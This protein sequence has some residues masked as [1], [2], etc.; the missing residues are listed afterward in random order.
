MTKVCSPVILVPEKNP[1]KGLIDLKY[2]CVLR[3]VLLHLMTYSH[4]RSRPVFSVFL[5]LSHLSIVKGQVDFSTKQTLS[6]TLSKNVWATVL[7]GSR[8]LAR[9][10]CICASRKSAQ[11]KDLFVSKDDKLLDSNLMSQINGTNPKDYKPDIKTTALHRHEELGC[12]DTGRTAGIWRV[13][14]VGGDPRLPCKK[15]R[16]YNSSSSNASLH[17]PAWRRRKI[18]S[19]RIVSR[20][21]RIILRPSVSES[22]CPHIVWILKH[23]NA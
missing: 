6:Q 5:W 18:S 9:S 21:S 11:L 23:H 13:P 12:P 19:F 4:L 10:R 17:F 22:P 3:Q 16:N 8:I 1:E 15:G 2:G 20:C 14:L 7:F